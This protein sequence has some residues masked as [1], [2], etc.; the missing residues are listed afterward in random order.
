MNKIIG[1]NIALPPRLLMGVSLHSQMLFSLTRW[2][3]LPAAL[4]KKFQMRN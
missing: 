3:C 2:L 4:A 1:I